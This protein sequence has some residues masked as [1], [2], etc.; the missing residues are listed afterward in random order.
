LLPMTA[1]ATPKIKVKTMLMNGAPIQAVIIVTK[2][3]KT[4][5][6]C[7][8][9]KIQRTQLRKQLVKIKTK[10]TMNLALTQTRKRVTVTEHLPQ[11]V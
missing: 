9:K 2:R 5:R 1:A 4:S 6:L 10:T 3:A 8:F 11:Q 7:K